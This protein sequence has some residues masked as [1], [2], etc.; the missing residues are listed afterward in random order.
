MLLMCP[1]TQRKVENFHSWIV[2]TWQCNKWIFLIAIECFY[3]HTNSIRCYG[4]DYW[5]SI[6]HAL[7]RRKPRVKW[8][9]TLM[10]HVTCPLHYSECVSFIVKCIDMVHRYEH[11]LN[12]SNNSCLTD[13]G[14]FMCVCVCVLFTGNNKGVSASIDFNVFHTI[15]YTIFSA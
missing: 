8:R 14:S 10:R 3:S 15:L 13:F 2:F 12:E 11:A 7:A 1:S 5:M 4:L 6:T 9:I